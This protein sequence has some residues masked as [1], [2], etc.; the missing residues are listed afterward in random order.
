MA[1]WGAATGVLYIILVIDPD[2]GSAGITRIM[3]HIEDK[4]AVARQRLIA[5][6]II[7]V[8]AARGIHVF[9]SSPEQIKR[10]KK[11]TFMAYLKPKIL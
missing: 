9:F 7:W 10:K 2:E 5:L 4:E 8:A 1:V 3:Y 6:A 11:C